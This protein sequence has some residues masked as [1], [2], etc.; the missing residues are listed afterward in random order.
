MSSLISI[1]LQAP[2]STTNVLVDF[3]DS[4]EKG[5]F[6]A[7]P[8]WASVKDLPTTLALPTHD[9]LAYYL[10]YKKQ[11][12]VPGYSTHDDVAKQWAKALVEFEGQLDFTALSLRLI[13]NA[14][15]D[16]GT[17]ERLGEAIGL[18]VASKLHGLHQADWSRIPES[19]KSKTLD[20]WRPC[21]ASDGRQFVQVEAKGSAS[22]NNDGKSSSISKHKASIKAKKQQVTA[23]TRSLSV[24]YGT[25]AVVDNRPNSTA[26]CWLVDPPAGVSGDP[27]RFRI[28]NRLKYI[29]ALISL[30]SPRSV[31]AAT[32]QTRL[33]ALESL[34]DIQELGGKPL[35]KG[36]GEQFST[37]TFLDRRR[38]HS[39]FTGR[40]VVTSE[41]IGGDICFVGKE[42]ILFIGLQEV[43]LALAT[44]QSF[45]EI[46]KYGY[47]ATTIERS[48]DCVI[49]KGR[50][51]RS[52][53]PYLKIPS[54]ELSEDVTGYAR[55]TMKGQ[56][57]CT[58]AGLVFGV[59]PI[60]KAWQ[61]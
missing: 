9:L 45:E 58:Q 32:L 56:L 60:P 33:S 61:K 24:L 22:D 7:S 51:A 16:T 29:G 40:S 37:E 41:S 25:I 28:V 38:H 13:P 46:Q 31:L 53:R 54:S 39:F 1:P 21:L 18:S 49:P 57:H 35:L 42:T 48:V 59:L 47:Q 23:D 55:F 17:T 5:L 10:Y 15:L 12:G 43:L 14:T 2:P 6:A 52:F 3:Y 20:F 4:A 19:N 34:E 27:I 36:D 11:P 26:R 50:F 8:L 30:I 44:A